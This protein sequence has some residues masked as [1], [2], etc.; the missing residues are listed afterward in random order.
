MIRP[1][2]LAGPVD[3]EM[4]FLTGGKKNSWGRLTLK[5]G[6]WSGDRGSFSEGKY[7]I[8]GSSGG[9]LKVLN[10]DNIL[11]KG[12]VTKEKKICSSDLFFIF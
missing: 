2:L 4:I 6:L 10:M 8:C 12:K 7:L 9:K 5:K 3:N 1:S 11:D